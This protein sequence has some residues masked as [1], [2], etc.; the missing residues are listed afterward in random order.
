MRRRGQPPG[1]LGCAK[2]STVTRT[3][4][5]R[6]P[7]PVGCR[8]MA[9]AA[10]PRPPVFFLQPQRAPISL[11]SPLAWSLHLF[12]P[13][14]PSQ[15][16]DGLHRCCRTPRWGWCPQRIC[17]SGTSQ[18]ISQALL[19]CSPTPTAR[20][21]AKVLNASSVLPRRLSRDGAGALLFRCM[22][23][24]NPVAER[25]PERPAWPAQE[26][27]SSHACPGHRLS[28]VGAAAGELLLC[29][30][31]PPAPY[32]QGK[33]NWMGILIIYYITVSY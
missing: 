33:D 10:A 27:G 30:E 24:T 5:A 8:F 18:P 25:P 6:A 31:P 23:K 1:A 29:T 19:G 2:N 14:V 4:L 22:G 15:G 32:H 28:G 20:L 11:G 26:R 21:S 17:C 16:G 3:A 9:S 12:P 7:V 13:T